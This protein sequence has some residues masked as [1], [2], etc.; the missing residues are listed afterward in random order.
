MSNIDAGVRGRCRLEPRHKLLPEHRTWII[1]QIRISINQTR[2]F[3][4]Q[5]VFL[6]LD[7]LTYWVETL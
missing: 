7:E 5:K 1:G 4:E 6:N 3:H 2:R